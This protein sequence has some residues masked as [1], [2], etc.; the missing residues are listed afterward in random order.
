[1][2]IEGDHN[3]GATVHA[4][5]GVKAQLQRS[6]SSPAGTSL[7][8]WMSRSYL[9]LRIASLT[10]RPQCQGLGSVRLIQFES[11][12]CL[13]AASRDSSEVPVVSGQGF[14]SRPKS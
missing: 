8:T 5:A 6:C 14:A 13:T 9:S 12:I 4:E 2:D 3:E 7:L 1:M 11:A 10:T